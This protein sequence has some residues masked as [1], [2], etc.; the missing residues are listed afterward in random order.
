MLSKAGGFF[1]CLEF[2]KLPKPIINKEFVEDFKPVIKTNGINYVVIVTSSENLPSIQITDFKAPRFFVLNKGDGV[3]SVLGI[4][5]VDVL[6]DPKNFKNIK[7]GFADF[8][9]FNNL[10]KD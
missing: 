3:F 7:N 4:A 1:A 8:I 6:N 9:G 5:L 10:I 2:L